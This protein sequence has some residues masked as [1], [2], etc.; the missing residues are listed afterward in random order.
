MAT[1]PPSRRRARAT[2]NKT[3]SRRSHSPSA[4]GLNR[5]LRAVVAAMGD[6]VFVLDANGQFL[7][8]VT[9]KNNFLQYSPAEIV[10]RRI[11]E[12]FPAD[13]R[14]DLTLNLIRRA[15]EIRQTVNYEYTF[16]YE[17]KDRW[18]AVM[19]LPVADDRVV[20]VARDVTE[21]RQFENLSE[22]QRSILELI[23]SG[24]PPNT[25]LMT[26][27]ETIEARSPGLL[28]S[29]MRLESDGRHLRNIVAPT[30]SEGFVRAIE[31]IAVGP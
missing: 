20:C 25:V 5:D 31:G 1:A 4:N 24:T 10:G 23:A 6:L 28:C 21:Q 26:L 30:L 18:L 7:E 8:A 2:A 19:F 13:E 16:R 15:L 29:I 17:G 27:A 14:A 11:Q 9:D 3:V 12:L 22:I